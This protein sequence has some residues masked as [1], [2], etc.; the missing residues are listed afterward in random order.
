MPT[1]RKEA[2]LCQSDSMDVL[3]NALLERVESHKASIPVITGPTGSGKSNLAMMLA[4]RIKGEIVSCDAMQ[5][6]RGFDIGTAKPTI[7]DQQA[8]PHHMIDILDPCEAMSVASY[9][10][11]VTDLLKRLLEDRKRPILCGG[12]VQYISALLD[13]LRFIGDSP[14]ATLREAVALEVEEKGLDASWK[15]IERLDPKSAE[16][17]APTDRTRI[18]R[19]FEMYRQT[20]LLKSEI[21]LRS[22]EGEVPFNYL[23]F[24]LDWTPRAAL[25]GAINARVDRMFEAGLVGEVKHLSEGV[26]RVEQCPAFRGIGYKEVLGHL[27]GQYS[28]DK[29]R[30]NIAQSTRRYA[31][32]QQT[33]LRKRKDL[34]ILL[35][36]R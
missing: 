5:V 25:Y 35:F 9:V 23:P 30:E 2:I 14:D 17:I 29:A 19:F 24:W 31:K 32:R 12:S 15:A 34:Q 22:R 3:F 1:T 10:N 6:Y 11:E 21:N 26:P 16:V 7:E 36:H 20:G 28:E 18:V 13:G 4:E 27:D 8:I 33:W